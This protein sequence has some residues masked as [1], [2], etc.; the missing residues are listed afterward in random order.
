MY[1]AR[2]QVWQQIRRAEI[3]NLDKLPFYSGTNNV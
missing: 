1:I 3:D 2:G